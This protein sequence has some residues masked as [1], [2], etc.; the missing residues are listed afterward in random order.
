MRSPVVLSGLLSLASA[1]VAGCGPAA[2][3]ARPSW[4]QDVFPILQGSC[5]HCHGE[6]VPQNMRPFTRLDV[7]DPAPFVAAGIML[8]APTTLGAVP[9]GALTMG[10]IVKAKDAERPVMPPPP[11]APL[12]DYDRDV[13][14]KW[15]KAIPTTTTPGEVHPSCRKQV[16]NRPPAAKLVSKKAD[17]GKLVVVLD[18]TDQDGDQV[19]GKVT[20][21]S[22][23]DAPSKL[24]T[25]SGRR[26]FEFDNLPESTEIKVLLVDGYEPPLE[27]IF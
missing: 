18:V 5:N 20:A 27:L 16:R 22:G 25:A 26:T 14:L 8:P 3:P 9:A 2:V 12:S 24:L 1:L 11:A 15:A 7:C 21:G 19:L 10:L 4:D 17:D 23:M 6:M 13:L